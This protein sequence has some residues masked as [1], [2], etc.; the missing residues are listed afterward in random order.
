MKWYESQLSLPVTEALINWIR[1]C[2]FFFLF[3][4]ICFRA[5]FALLFY[6]ERIFFLF[7]I[8]QFSKN[9]KKWNKGNLKQQLQR[10]NRKLKAWSTSWKLVCIFNKN[11][12]FYSINSYIIIFG[13]ANRG[14]H[15]KVVNEMR[16]VDKANQPEKRKK[17]SS[18][19]KEKNLLKI[20]SFHSL[21]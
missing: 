5:L 2:S 19:R 13:L 15:S 8:S 3:L 1:F 6:F 10:H 7:C 18:Q 9:T 21:P 17:L 11:M 4:F 20:D 16:G 14:T 12:M